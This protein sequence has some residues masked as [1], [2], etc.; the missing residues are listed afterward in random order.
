[1]VLIRP[2]ITSL[3]LV[4]TTVLIVVLIAEIS[5]LVKASVSVLFGAANKGLPVVAVI[6]VV[7]KAR[8]KLVTAVGWLPVPV[9]GKPGIVSAFLRP[10]PVNP[11]IVGARAWRD[12]GCVRR[13]RLIETGAVSSEAYVDCYSRFGNIEPPAKS[14]IANNFVFMVRLPSWFL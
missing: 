10:V 5:I 6:K 14:I 2:K 13:R 11:R 1:L 7:L 8:R 9:S 4:G 3:V 12:S